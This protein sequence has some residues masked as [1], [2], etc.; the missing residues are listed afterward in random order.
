MLSENFWSILKF[1]FFR[2]PQTLLQL[3]DQQL[4]RRKMASQGALISKQET[5]GYFSGVLQVLMADY[6]IKPEANAASPD[7]STW[8]LLLKVCSRLENF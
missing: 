3:D 7:T 5:T 4:R 6:Q 8:P 1:H 2:P